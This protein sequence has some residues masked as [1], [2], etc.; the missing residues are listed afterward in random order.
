MNRIAVTL[1]ND[2]E[3][4]HVGIWHKTYRGRAG[5]YEAIYSGMPAFGLG[6]IGRLVLATGR[7]ESVRGR[8][9]AVAEATND[10]SP[11]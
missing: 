10:G 8:L 11:G 5:E 6:R 4:R 7:R 2:R 9:Q 3:L 1:A